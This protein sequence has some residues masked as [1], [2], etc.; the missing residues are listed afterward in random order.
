MT[1]DEAK[2]AIRDKT[3]VKHE[4]L[5]WDSWGTLTCLSDDE[6]TAYY[7]RKGASLF[8]SS[9]TVDKIVVT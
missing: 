3:P 6:T 1:V 8:R 4:D 9:M 7:N 5:T 2:K